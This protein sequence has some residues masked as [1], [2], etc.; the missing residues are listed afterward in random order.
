[1][2]SQTVILK[3]NKSPGVGHTCCGSPSSV[4]DLSSTGPSEQKLLDDNFACSSICMETRPVNSSS[5]LQ[6]PYF[7]PKSL[8][9]L[10]TQQVP[11]AFV[12]HPHP[13]PKFTRSSTFCASLYSSPST[14]SETLQLGSL[15]FLPH[16]C[17]RD[18]PIPKTESPLLQHGDGHP[19]PGDTESDNLMDFLDLTGGAT[20]GNFYT[21]N[22]GLDNIALSKE[23]E[24]Q[25]LSEELDIAII[26]NG[27][28]PGLDEIYETPSQASNPG[29]GSKCNV[30]TYQDLHPPLSHHFPLNSATSVTK[31]VHKPRL[32]W[33]LDLHERFLEAV[34]KLDGAEKAT[35]KG[36][37]QLMH[38]EGLTIYHIKS[39]LQKYRLAKYIP[40][41]KEEN[42]SPS[43]EDKKS[44]PINSESGVGITRS[45]QVIEA[46]RIQMEVQKQLH[47][48][49]ELQR[50]LQLRIEEQA[51][52]L[53]RML[54]EQQKAGNTLLPVG[55]PS[56]EVHPG[57]PPADTSQKQT[58]S[59][60]ES[61][62][63]LVPTANAT[64]S[65]IEVEI[66][67]DLKRPR[68]EAKPEVDSDQLTVGNGVH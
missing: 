30:E 42:K 60:I 7:K 35:P 11:D 63:D 45:M 9:S 25:M 27:E 40:E 10:T 32:R 3:Q 52:Y 65:D 24:L 51:R 41:K 21:G 26:D 61:T 48:Q 17:K 44:A 13:K 31:T 50:A 37:L 1:M 18:Q 15:P 19:Y 57:S 68:S 6:G 12:S 62:S 36:I 34:K 53:Q 67:L 2:N 43:S 55:S 16:P 59:K 46:L 14:S 49:L 38:V 33:T 66:K 23:M 8:D 58:E 29:I 39:H 56:S 47:E 22:Y 20:D 64:E 4:H 28:S 54:E 5:H